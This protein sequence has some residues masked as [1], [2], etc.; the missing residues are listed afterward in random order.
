MNGDSRR[1]IDEWLQT[2]T[3]GPEPTCA[4]VENEVLG[5]A[6]CQRLLGTVSIGRIVF[7]VGALPAVHPVNFVVD[8]DEILFRTNSA[9]KLAAATR[10]AIVAFEVDAFD[11]ATARRGRR[12]AWWSS[13]WRCRCTTRLGFYELPPTCTRGRQVRRC[14]W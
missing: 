13:V 10:N 3:G 2:Q 14:T 4:S 5:L 6:E 9:T 1:V 8:G 7:T 12:G 11:G